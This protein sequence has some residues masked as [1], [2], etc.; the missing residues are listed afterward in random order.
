MLREQ[1]VSG[2]RVCVG[3]MG[4]GGGAARVVDAHALSSIA[5]LGS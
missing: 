3:R 5:M 4:S 2:G 1:G